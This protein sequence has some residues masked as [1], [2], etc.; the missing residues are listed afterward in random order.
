MLQGLPD[1]AL[2]V[3]DRSEE[4]MRPRM[5]ECDPDIAGLCLPGA[6]TSS[7]TLAP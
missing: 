2:L 4:G 6:Y 5:V 7:L 3:A 1:H